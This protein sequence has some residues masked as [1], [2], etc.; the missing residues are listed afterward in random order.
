ML[1]IFST[2]ILSTLIGIVISS[3]FSEMP[4]KWAKKLSF[5]CFL[6]ESLPDI[7]VAVSAQALVIW[8]FKKTDVLLFNVASSYKE[9]AFFIPL[10]TLC[11][12]PTLFITRLLLVRIEEEK[13]E[14]YYSMAVAK[15]ISK[16]RIMLH[17]LMPNTL[18][19]LITQVKYL[20]WYILSNLVMIEY[21]FNL[22][23]ITS[24]IIRFNNP[25]VFIVSTLLLFIP[26]YLF[27]QS[28]QVV[29]YR[30]IGVRTE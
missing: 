20:L 7:F 8:Y 11:I 14:P 30:S 9:Q 10:F 25:E 4:K 22:N 26:L 2:I 29:C 3:V 1:L 12:L 28:L 17:H 15:G 24:F 18:I 21:I 5:V 6:S 19:S 16:C 13:N 27:S 23:G